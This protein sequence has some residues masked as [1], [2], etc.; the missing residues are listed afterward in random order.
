MPLLQGF[1]T[2]RTVFLPHIHAKLSETEQ[3]EVNEPG[4]ACLFLFAHIPLVCG[5]HRVF[6]LPVSEGLVAREL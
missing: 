2:N 3:S 1:L 4:S 5:N 6:N